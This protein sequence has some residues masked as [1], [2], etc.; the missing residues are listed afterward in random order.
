[1]MDRGEDEDWFSSPFIV[2]MALL[3]FLGIGGAILWLLVAKKPIVNL[4]VFKDKNF[5]GGCLM[6]GAMGAD[7]LRQR[8]DHSRN[9]RN[10]SSAIPRPGPA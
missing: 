10:R 8:R 9:S 2:T 6:I 1:M 4:D 3:A 5:T 7:P